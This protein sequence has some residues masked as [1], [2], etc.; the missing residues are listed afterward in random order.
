MARR[1]LLTV[2]R[3]RPR[4]RRRLST[5][6]PSLVAMRCRKPCLRR[7]GMR[8]G[9]HVRF[10]IV[11]YT[12]LRTARSAAPAH[13]MNLDG[14]AEAIRRKPPRRS[15]RG[16]AIIH[17]K[18]AGCQII[19]GISKTFHAR[20]AGRNDEPGAA[21]RNLRPQSPAL[22][23]RGPALADP[24]LSIRR[25]PSAGASGGSR[26]VGG[27]CSDLPLPRRRCRPAVACDR[28]CRR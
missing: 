14:K 20:E 2:K 3:Q 25:R 7:R 8:F 13:H 21:V 1:S 17:R 12:S 19:W 26:R 23:W 9:C 15:R 4:S 27:A 6:R 24:I 18:G 5:S 16:D 11:R 28:A 10:G 22:V